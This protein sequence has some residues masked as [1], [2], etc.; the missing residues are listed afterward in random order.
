[1]ASDDV[2][3]ADDPRRPVG[4]GTVL[5]GR[6]TL[7][8]LLDES[9][10]ARFWR[11]Y[12]DTL[13]RYVA[14]HVIPADDERAERLLEAARTS[15]V[16]N[17]GHILRVLDAAREPDIAYVVVEWG[18]G[19]S[20]DRMLGEGPLSARRAAWLVKE[21][22]EAITAAHREGVPH[23][24][25]IPENV[26]V[27]E[28]GAVKIIGFVIEAAL[29]P[30]GDRCVNGDKPTDAMAADVVNLAGLLY[31]ALVGRWPGTRGSSVADAPVVHGHVLRPRQVRPGVPRSLDAVC[32]RVLNP[33]MHPH[34][35][36]ISS[37]HEIYAALSDYGTDLAS[38]PEATTM[39]TPE[40]R[41]AALSDDPDA[42]Q[43]GVPMF[44]EEPFEEPPPP[45][46]L[47]EPEQRPLFAP[48]PPEGTRPVRRTTAER[49]ARSI[50]A[51]NGMVPPE[52][53]PDAQ[54]PPDD[55]PDDQWTGS[56]DADG[57]GK[58]WLR[59]AAI[60][61]GVLMLLFGVIFAF[62]LG[63]HP[64]AGTPSA[65][66][67]SSG[68][69]VPDKGLKLAIDGVVDFDPQGNPPTENPDETQFAIDGKPGTAWDTLTYRG[70]PKLGGLKTGVGLLVDLGSAK[71]LD[72]VQ[73][74]LIGAP[75]ALQILTAPGATS[76]PTTNEG[77]TVSATE[78]AA[79]TDVDLTFKK[80]VTTRYFVVWLTS[81]PPYQNGYRGQ[82]A[83]ITPWS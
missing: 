23:G 26:M 54:A 68:P 40:E 52:W 29:R 4:P 70:N 39:I 61:F 17:D 75:T 77:L 48:D 55:E 46:V 35:P 59:V 20:L 42:T 44:D 34:A 5:A 18:S 6:F 1:V 8:D 27:N 38:G 62:N 49:P 81:L 78:T 21:V 60:V 11:A 25:L 41:L 64:D 43:V 47:P 12:D 50:G 30:G 51:G 19:I 74:T 22:A 37:A 58:S 83:E 76:A 3:T 36:P 13:A 24:R 14:V 80:A 56:W 82:V 53:G 69:T 73:V 79:G 45:P 31:A 66:Q 67:T 2:D 32:D 65:T 33:G 28:A 71:Q 16:V 57:P 7:E 72:R 10:G 9:G 15:A 63:R